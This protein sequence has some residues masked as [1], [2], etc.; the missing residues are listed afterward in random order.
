MK[1]SLPVEHEL[2]AEK[3]A[4]LAITAERLERALAALAEAEQAF[5]AA[6]EEEKAALLEKHRGL[7]AHAAER[8]WFLIVQ[9][10]A[11]GLTHHDNVLAFYRV[12][13]ELRRRVVPARLPRRG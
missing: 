2:H 10:E 13:P 1:E 12:P 3:A 5:A 6:P 7:R 4:A 8:L 11:M 9:R